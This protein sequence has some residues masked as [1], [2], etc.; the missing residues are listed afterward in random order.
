MVYTQPDIT[1]MLRKLSQHIKD[2]ADFY[3]EAVK[4][5]I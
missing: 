3:I 1:F 5:L 2:P 4:N